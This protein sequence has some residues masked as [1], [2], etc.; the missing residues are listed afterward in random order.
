[1]NQK[2]KLFE[3][4][5]ILNKITC[6]TPSLY[7]KYAFFSY[8]LQYLYMMRKIMQ[9]FMKGYWWSPTVTMWTEQLSCSF[10][11]Y[12]HPLGQ[13]TTAETH[14]SFT[15]KASGPALW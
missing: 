13:H 8:L 9:W 10:Q 15:P 3:M 11:E 12:I 2:S 1:M 5:N 7:S 4:A 6:S 14:N